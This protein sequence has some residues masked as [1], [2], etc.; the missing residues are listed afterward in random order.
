[1]KESFSK[2]QCGANAESCCM[3]WHRESQWTSNKT[4]GFIKLVLV[5]VL[6]L[7]LVLLRP[8]SRSCT[9][10]NLRVWVNVKSSRIS[11]WMLFGAGACNCGGDDNNRHKESFKRSRAAACNALKAIPEASKTILSNIRIATL[12]PSRNMNSAKSRPWVRHNKTSCIL[13][14]SVSFGVKKQTPK[15]ITQ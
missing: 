13:L 11:P 6:L 10:R 5:L 9:S 3:A 4:E 14:N 1:M 7:L 2:I 8:P 15:G 12:E